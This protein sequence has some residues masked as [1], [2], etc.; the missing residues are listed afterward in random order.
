MAPGTFPPPPTS[1]SSNKVDGNQARSFSS[2]K[3]TADE[4]VNK[5]AVI[6]S[7]IGRQVEILCD[8]GASVHLTLDRED[9]VSN[10]PT[11][12]TCTF[13]NNGKLEAKETGDMVPM[14]T[15]KDGKPTRV[16]LK[17]VLWVPGLPCRILSTGSI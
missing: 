8:S 16:V 1:G 12:H 15:D 17:D 11:K 2:F 14:V 13:G 3:V 4:E 9:L 6:N 5:R 7:S 10:Q